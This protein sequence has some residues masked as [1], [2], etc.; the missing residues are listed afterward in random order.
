[1]HPS[2]FQTFSGMIIGLISG[3]NVQHH[4]LARHV[5][6]SSQ[7]AAV[8]RVELFFK[9]QAL[10]MEMYALTVVYLLSF[11]GKFKL[12]LDRTNWKIGRKNVN[13]LVLSW[14]I[15]E[16][17]SL[18]LLAVELDKAGNSNTAERV[19]LIQRFVR[20]F[21]AN[22]IAEL[23]ADREFVGDQWIRYLQ[24]NR[25][26][27]FV[28]VKANMQIPFG[29]GTCDVKNFITGWDEGRPRKI[30]KE[31]FGTTVYFA[32]KMLKDGEALIVIIPLHTSLNNLN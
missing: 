10:S 8:K 32:C 27:F 11:F 15:S 14:H 7:K 20:I 1:M 21:G 16:Q 3:A 12:R 24:E 13:Y 19:D 2:R 30:E 22:R 5:N 4:G 18:P 28:R 25:I 26:P 17:I 29:N 23:V 31:M 6:S 9:D